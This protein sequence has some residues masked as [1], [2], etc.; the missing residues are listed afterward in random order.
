M[1]NPKDNCVS[2]YHFRKGSAFAQYFGSFSEFCDLFMA[3]VMPWGGYW[4]SIKQMWALRGHPNIHYVFYEDLKK[5]LMA[6]LEKLNQFFEFNLSED[7]LK[8]YVRK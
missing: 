6:E 8:R 2:Y 5:N 1:R 4:N 7:Q 3:E